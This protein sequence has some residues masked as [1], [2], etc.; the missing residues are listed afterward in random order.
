MTSTLE[1]Q[2]TA[3]DASAVVARLRATFASGR[4][5]PVDYR[6]QQLRALD[7]LLVEAEED[8]LAAFPTTSAS[9]RWRGTSPTS[10][11]CGPRSPTPCATSTAGWRRRG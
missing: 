9:P 1:P 5:R 11:S 8:L 4:T 6:K 2:V 7:R 10:R 3:T